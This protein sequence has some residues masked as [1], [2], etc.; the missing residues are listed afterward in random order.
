MSDDFFN[1][2]GTAMPQFWRCPETNC[3]WIRTSDP[4]FELDKHCTKCDEPFV[5]CDCGTSCIGDKAMRICANIP[6]LNQK[7]PWR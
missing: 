6:V 4:R 1:I 2:V 7:C 3:P 5:R